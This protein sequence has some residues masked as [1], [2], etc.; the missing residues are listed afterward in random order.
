M[1]KPT[2]PNPNALKPKNHDYDSLSIYAAEVASIA[3]R[4][5]HYSSSHL[6]ASGDEKF[7]GAQNL[8]QNDSGYNLVDRSFAGQS[9]DQR[10]E[11]FSDDVIFFGYFGRN[12]KNVILF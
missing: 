2:S 7:D 12:L 5:H 9:R 11:G 1:A 3:S 10:H 4:D 6:Y 8:A